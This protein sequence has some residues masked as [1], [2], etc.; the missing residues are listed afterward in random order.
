MT[1]LLVWSPPLSTDIEEVFES[2][3]PCDGCENFVGSEC[4][5]LGD[6]GSEC[7]GIGF[8]PNR[9]ILG[10]VSLKGG[11]MPTNPAFTL[12]EVHEG[13]VTEP[14]TLDFPFTTRSISM[15]NDSPSRPLL[16]K[17]SV[18][19]DFATLRPRETVNCEST[20]LFVIIDGDNVPYRIWG[21]G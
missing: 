10:I 18:D 12:M 21:F 6:E 17:F 16:F 7:P 1:L 19:G 8:S 2:S 13:E 11:P 15:M 14:T 4:L 20:V 9:R 3:Y 5:A